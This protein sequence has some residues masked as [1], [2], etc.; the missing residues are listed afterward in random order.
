MRYYATNSHC[1]IYTCFFI[2]VGRTYFLGKWVALHPNFDNRRGRS[3]PQRYDNTCNNG[4]RNILNRFTR[5]E[6]KWRA[7]ELT[8]RLWRKAK[9]NPFH[10]LDCSQIQRR[11]STDCDPPALLPKLMSHRKDKGIFFSSIG[12]YLNCRALST[13]G[14]ASSRSQRLDWCCGWRGD[15]TLKV[16]AR[17]TWLI[18]RISHEHEDWLNG[19]VGTRSHASKGGSLNIHMNLIIMGSEPPSRQCK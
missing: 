18:V 13:E 15:W 10:S 16:S 14:M 19:G 3:S 8:F 11:L 1:L 12:I 7:S 6:H 5:Q 9:T 2:K 4:W 17:V